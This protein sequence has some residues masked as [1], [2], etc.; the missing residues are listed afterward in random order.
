V[1]RAGEEV[2]AKEIEEQQL[3]AA[4]QASERVQACG[5]GRD[6]G[7]AIRAALER[8]DVTHGL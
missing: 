5:I 4:N 8:R 2:A 3:A 1:R 6:L 7:P